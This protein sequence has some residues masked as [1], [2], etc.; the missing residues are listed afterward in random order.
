MEVPDKLL[1]YR[2]KQ[3]KPSPIEIDEIISLEEMQRRYLPSADQ[4]QGD[5]RSLASKLGI[6]ESTLYRKLKEL[7]ESD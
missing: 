6:S 2:S 7:S 4:R 3:S 1:Q 5:R